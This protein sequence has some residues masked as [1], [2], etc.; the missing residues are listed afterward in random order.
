MLEHPLA[1]DNRAQ[2]TR[3]IAMTQVI[4]NAAKEPKS[5]KD[6]AKWQIALPTHGAAEAIGKALHELGYK[7][8]IT[9]ILDPTVVWVIR[10]AAP[11]DKIAR[12]KV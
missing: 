3:Q 6:W 11:L 2:R 1:P 9:G 8:S 12:L 4:K 7:T 5:S 10:T